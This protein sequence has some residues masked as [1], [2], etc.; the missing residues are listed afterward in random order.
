[1]RNETLQKLCEANENVV[2]KTSRFPCANTS[3][4]SL[5][6]T[7]KP[8][9]L[10]NPIFLFSF[11]FVFFPMGCFILKPITF[12]F[13]YFFCLNEKQMWGWFVL[14]PIMFEF[15]YFFSLNEE[16]MWGWFVLKPIMFVFAYF[17]CLNEKPMWGWFVLKP[18]TFV[19]A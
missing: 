19:F 15:A 4:P 1:M 12:V 14:K 8:N 13:A 10:Q 5:L 7:P 11:Q 9:F 16:Q 17:F 18:I 2:R 6:H 3:L